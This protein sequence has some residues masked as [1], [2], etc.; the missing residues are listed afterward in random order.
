MVTPLSRFLLCRQILDPFALLDH[1]GTQGTCDPVG[2][3]DDEVQGQDADACE[4]AQ[5][6]GQGHTDRPDKAAVEEEGD[7]GLTAGAEGEVG[8]IGVG[9]EGHHD[10]ADAD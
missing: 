3:L 6:E 2:G 10:A 8:C 4:P 9:I 1:V 5:D 7:H